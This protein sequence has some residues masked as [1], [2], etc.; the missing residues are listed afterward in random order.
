MPTVMSEEATEVPAF[1]CCSVGIG[2]WFWVAWESEAQARALAP[3]L[4]SGYEAS[5]DRAAG[6]AAERLG[7]RMKHLP[8]KWASGYKRRGG[9]AARVSSTEQEAGGGG[10]TRPRARFGRPG[11]P[12]GRRKVTTR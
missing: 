1:A 8:A 7:P 10:E 11:G 3:P 5:V 9:I 4:A 12:P 6:K 2:R